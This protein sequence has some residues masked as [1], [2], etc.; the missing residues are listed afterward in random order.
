MA[1]STVQQQFIAN[2]VYEIAETSNL[3][4]LLKEGKTEPLES[5]VKKLLKECPH[6]GI[7]SL[8]K[9]DTSVVVVGDNVGNGNVNNV[10]IV[11]FF[12]NFRLYLRINASYLPCTKPV[13]S[14]VQIV[15]PVVREVVDYVPID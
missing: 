1:L 8:S 14:S 12:V 3:I 6:D 11:L 2:S 10:E 4:D 15:R 5:S 13:V 7:W 9:E